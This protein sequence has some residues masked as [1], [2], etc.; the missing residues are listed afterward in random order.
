[1]S[2]AQLFD[3]VAARAEPG[4]GDEASKR[5]AAL[6]A[7][8]TE[9]Q[10]AWRQAAQAGQSMITTGTP[11]P[12]EVTRAFPGLIR[13][14]L[15]QAARAAPSRER[16]LALVPVADEIDRGAGGSGMAAWLRGVA[17]EDLAKRAPLAASYARLVANPGSFT[18]AA[19]DALL[20]SL[21][22]AKQDDLVLGALV[23]LGRV[24]AS[25]A[26]VRQLAE[27]RH[28][29]WALAIAD[30]ADAQAALAKGDAPQ[31]EQILREA[32][33]RC[34]SAHVDYQCA[35]LE[36]DLADALLRQ[37][38]AVE[39]HQQAMIGLGRA[40]AA[41]VDARDLERRYFV[42]LAEIARARNLP[43][44]ATAYVGEA[45]LHMP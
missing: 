36:Y 20:A 23:L 22:K 7:E 38:R 32:D 34:L 29:P 41:G 14:D 15:Y 28:D 17:A 35:F 1:L 10:Q 5:A 44:L 42:L 43:A 12:A 4:W 39:A 9:R 24:A 45:R 18:P 19:G 13:R 27:Q 6:R 3:A 8:E 11:P 40:R 21:R 26:E 25:R 33:K 31:A 2:A 30:Q 37:S 16:V